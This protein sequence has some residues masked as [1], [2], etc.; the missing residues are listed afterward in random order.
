MWADTIGE[1][2]KTFGAVTASLAVSKAALT[3]WKGGPGKRRI[4]IRNYR[5]LAPSVRPV[6]VEQMFGQATFSHEIPSRDLIPERE[7][8]PEAWDENKP[9]MAKVWVLGK[10]GYLTTWEIGDMV[11]AYSL[12]T[13]RWRFCPKIRIGPEFGGTKVRLGWTR[14]SALNE[15]NEWKSFRGAHN[16]GYI[17]QHYFGN[18]GEYQTWHCGVTDAGYQKHYVTPLD[19]QQEQLQESNPL[20]KGVDDVRR[21]WLEFR[22]GASINCILISG[23]WGPNIHFTT[24]GP[25]VQVRLLW[26]IGRTQRLRLKYQEWKARRKQ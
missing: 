16:Y 14:F 1:A 26:R 24:A 17:E 3:A 10:D 23:G 7:L 5:R 18:P 8:S 15:P 4:W 25:P 9:I 20:E 19:G 13:A 21:K 11:L 12:A 22:S 6:Y 2:T